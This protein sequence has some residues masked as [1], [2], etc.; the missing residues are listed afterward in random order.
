M[1]L[2]LATSLLFVLVLVE[3]AILKF[4]M[5]EQIP[6]REVISNLNSGHILF[7][8]FRGFE[9]MAFQWV[10]GHFSLGWVVAWPVGLQWEARRLPP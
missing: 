6:W 5:N 8:I 10:F 2:F 9:L 7:W 3:L 1:S 4:S